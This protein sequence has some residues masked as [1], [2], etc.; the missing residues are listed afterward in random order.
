MERGKVYGPEHGMS[1]ATPGLYAG[2][3]M[4]QRPEL[5]FEE[6]GRLM[7]PVPAREFP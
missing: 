5:P 4:A 1:V 2:T 3:L 6:D 7:D